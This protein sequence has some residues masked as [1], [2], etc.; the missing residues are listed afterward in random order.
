MNFNPVKLVAPDTPTGKAL[1]WGKSM[2]D[3]SLMLAKQPSAESLA[4][5]RLLLLLKPRYTMVRN[6]NLVNLYRLVQELGRRGVPGDIVECGTWNGGSAAMMALALSK[7]PT[8]AKRSL[9]LFD[10]F[11]GLP[12]PGQLDGTLE[13][14]HYFEGLNKGSQAMVLEAFRK[15]LAPTHNL[16]VVKG[17][18]E[19][20]LPRAEVQ[21]ISLL[22]IDADWF[23][24]VKLVLDTFY[25][26]VSP[27]GY[28]VLDDFDYWEG[29]KRAL[30]AFCQERDIG[31]LEIQK[32]DRYGAFF[33]KL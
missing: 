32:V 8:G 10:S 4:F 23:E 19:D 7:D 15:V 24:S 14:E 33:R 1:V 16:H 20:T 26:R 29:C 17:W 11:E 18:F 30:D 27:G 28:L 25:D 3:T 6:R 22:H 13:Q 9:W 31:K 21:Q 12:P 2:L 5:A